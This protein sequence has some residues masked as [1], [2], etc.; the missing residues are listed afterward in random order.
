MPYE[1][2]KVLHITGIFTVLFAISA[3]IF[4]VLSGGTKA[5]NQYRRKLAIMHGVGLLVTLVAG[6]GLLARLGI[7]SS[8]M[9]VSI[10]ILIWVFLGAVSA[11]IY[12]QPKI[13]G[14]IWWTTLLLTFVAAYLA[15]YKPA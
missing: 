5:T 14:A 3:H 1:V 15:V 9:W 6:F 8:P 10:K 12:R 2:Y 11:I 7:H 4:H 13:A